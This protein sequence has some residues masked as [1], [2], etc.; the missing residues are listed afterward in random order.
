M[1][2][3]IGWILAARDAETEPGVWF[4]FYHDEEGTVAFD[5]TKQHPH[6][7]YRGFEA[8][9][10]F[11]DASPATEKVVLL[12]GTERSDDALIILHETK[13]ATPESNRINDEFSFLSYNYVALPGKPPSLTT[14]DNKPG[15]IHLKQP[16]SLLIAMG[17]RIF[18]SAKLEEEIKAGHWVCLPATPELVFGTSRHD[19]RAKLLNRLN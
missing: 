17:Y 15:T 11:E 12:G 19:R 18:D 16:S 10:N 4:V 3:R 2:V 14:P 8:V 9:L 13:A 7:F 5:I 1:T 6:I